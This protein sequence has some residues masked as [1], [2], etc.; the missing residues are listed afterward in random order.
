[1]NLFLQHVHYSP[2]H[3]SILNFALVY[4]ARVCEHSVLP[5]VMKDS[6]L[7]VRVILRRWSVKTLVLSSLRC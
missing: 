3:C 2:I 6:L 1:M 7:I 4:L 5:N